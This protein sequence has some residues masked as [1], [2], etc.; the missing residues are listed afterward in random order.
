[1]FLMVCWGAADWA[2]QKHLPRA[3][4]P[5][6]SVVILIA[7]SVLTHRQVGFWSDRVKLWTHTLQVTHRNWIAETHLADDDLQHGRTDEALA[8]YYRAEED[9][10]RSQGVNLNIA[11]IEHKRGNLRPAIEH[12]L[13]VLAV[14]ED[15][16]TKT[17]VLANLGHAYSDL[18][19]FARAQECYR[20]ALHPVLPPRP[21]ID[22]RGE[23]WRDLGPWLRQY[24]HKWR[25]GV[26]TPA[27]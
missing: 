19:D 5:V 16:A 13:R 25:S 26:S 7:L 1:L 9:E 12:Y 6:T 8:R 18:G 10:P 27:Q 21:A 3:V 23:W 20:A 24:L 11:L 15:E 4:L 22:W 17:Q 14:S 2:E